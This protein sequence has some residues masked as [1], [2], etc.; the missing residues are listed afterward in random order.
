M[1]G[2][3]IQLTNLTL[4]DAYAF[5]D[6]TTVPDVA[7]VASVV[8]SQSVVASYSRVTHTVGSFVGTSPSYLTIN[9]DAAAAGTVIS[10]SDFVS[11]AAIADL[12]ATVATDLFGGDGSAAVNKTVQLDGKN[13]LV[14]GCCRPRGP[15]AFGTSTT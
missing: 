1:T 12:G 5:T 11:H 9:N 10:D 3:S 8:T 7:A 4:D 13:F 6:H 15:R 14:L 2:P